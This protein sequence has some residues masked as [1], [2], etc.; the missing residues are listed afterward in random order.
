MVVADYRIE[1]TGPQFIVIDPW[2]ETVDTYP[3][4]E[5]AT[6]RHGSYPL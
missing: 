4:E 3:T 6:H 2:G 1:Q 5:A